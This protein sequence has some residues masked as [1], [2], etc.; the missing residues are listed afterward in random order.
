[1]QIGLQAKGIL[2]FELQFKGKASHG[3]LPWEGLN[4]VLQALQ[5]HSNC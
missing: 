3:S 5:F 2:Q 4:A 1:M